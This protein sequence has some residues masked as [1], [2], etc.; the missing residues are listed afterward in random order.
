MDIADL[1]PHEKLRMPLSGSDGIRPYVS[2]S[3]ESEVFADKLLW[4]ASLNGREKTVRNLIASYSFKRTLKESVN[5][6]TQSGSTPLLLAAQR[7]HVGIVNILLKSGAAT[8]IHDEGGRLPLHSAAANGH[9]QI[10]ELLLKAGANSSYA[11]RGITAEEAAKAA[12]HM[13]AAAVLGRERQF[14]KSN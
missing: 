14:P 10:V 2:T 6:Q 13:E 7:G 9:T 5:A 11:P 3:D 1:V 8:D 4:V 12:G